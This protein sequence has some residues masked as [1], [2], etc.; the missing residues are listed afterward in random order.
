M[1]EVLLVLIQYNYCTVASFHVP[2]TLYALQPPQVIT[3][4]LYSNVTLQ[5]TVYRLQL[6]EYANVCSYC[7]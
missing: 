3:L 6:Y 1:Y 4:S 5:L 7:T 2:A